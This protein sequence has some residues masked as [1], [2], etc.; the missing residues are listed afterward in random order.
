MTIHSTSYTVTLIGLTKN[1]L[2]P[3][4]SLVPSHQTVITKSKA[5]EK[6]P[7]SFVIWTDEGLFLSNADDLTEN[8]TTLFQSAVE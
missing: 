6:Y 3:I 4:N 8:I 5:L 1:E 2:T 7:Y